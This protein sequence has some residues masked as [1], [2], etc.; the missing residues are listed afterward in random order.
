MLKGILTILKPGATFAVI[1]HAAADGSGARD[2]G[3]LHRVDEATVV[4]EITAA[5]FELIDTSDL[6][7][8]P[9]DDRTL[10]VFDDKIR[11]K[12][13]QFILKFRKPSHEGP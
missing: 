6:L 5:G 3:T 13:D 1:D 8:R 9:E 12:T 11:G 10:P 4:S 2:V 7:R